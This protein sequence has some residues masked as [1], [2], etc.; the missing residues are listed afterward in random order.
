MNRRTPLLALAGV[1]AL[2]VLML[3]GL[4]MPKSRQVAARRQEVAAAQEQYRALQGRLQALQADQKEAGA[5]RK[6]LMQLESEV[7]TTADLPGLIRLLDAAADRA[8]VDFM[9]LSPQAPTL[10]PEGGVSLIPAN[11]TVAG[12]FFAVD[13]FLYELETL[14]RASR[15]TS[16]AVTQ[17]PEGPP[18]LQVVVSL[19]FFT[20]DTSAGPGSQPGPVESPLPS[21]APGGSPSPGASPSPG[22]SPSPGPTASPTPSG[23]IPF[24]SETATG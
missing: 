24:P 16:V 17:G 20:T 10:A 14:P 22:G 11:I 18:Q 9:S 19:R 23:P 5:N 6:T 21:P 1:I 12:T 13:R 4:V 2:I 8:A 7:P 15:V 3:V